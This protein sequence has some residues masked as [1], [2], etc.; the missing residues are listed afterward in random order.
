MGTGSPT[1][2]SLRS[3][4]DPYCKPPG[5]Q[6]GSPGVIIISDD[7]DPKP[8][9]E[10]FLATVKGSRSI[11]DGEEESYRKY[12]LDKL[13]KNSQYPKIRSQLDKISKFLKQADLISQSIC[14]RFLR[15]F[16]KTAKRFTPESLELCIKNFVR[17]L[18]PRQIEDAPR[19]VEVNRLL[20]GSPILPLCDRALQRYV[21]SK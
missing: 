14:L 5:A 2:P 16:F 13:E 1:K 20:V 9:L 15:T 8:S 11:E 3:T 17:G 6:V 10:A 18:V 21:Y 12:T 19:E 4:S 7:D